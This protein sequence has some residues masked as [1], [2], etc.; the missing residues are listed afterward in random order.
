M[1]SFVLNFIFINAFPGG[2]EIG[3]DVDTCLGFLN[4]TRKGGK[5][6]A[7]FSSSWC[8]PL[9]DASWDLKKIWIFLQKNV[10]KNVSKI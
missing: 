4:L 5:N 7:S 6:A 9:G 8:L 1:C 3:I 2:K 10:A